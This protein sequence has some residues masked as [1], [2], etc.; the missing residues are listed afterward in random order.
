MKKDVLKFA[1]GLGIG[2]L[3][4]LL[5]IKKSSD[6]EKEEL[7]HKESWNRERIGIFQL[8][9]KGKRYT[10]IEKIIGYL[11][12]K[13][14]EKYITK[15]INDRNEI[16]PDCEKQFSEV[17]L[18]K[19]ADKGDYVMFR[20]FYLLNHDS[21]QHITGGNTYPKLLVDE[22]IISGIFELN[23]SEEYN[24]VQSYYKIYSILNNKFELSVE[25][26]INSYKKINL[27]IR[28]SIEYDNYS[29]KL[30]LENLEI[31]TKEEFRNTDKNAE[32]ISESKKN[33]YFRS[34]YWNYKGESILE[35]EGFDLPLEVVT[36]YYEIDDIYL[37]TYEDNELEINIAKS[38]DEKFRYIIES[39]LKYLMNNTDIEINIT[40]VRGF[41]E[42]EKTSESMNKLDALI[43]ETLIRNNHQ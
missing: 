30:Y 40:S 28:Y 29:K 35:K 19:I 2:A 32:I 33:L 11:I 37:G 36:H 10:Y 16:F 23:K 13:K 5:L 9:Y 20:D 25:R 8:T 18:I 41:I 17:R 12:Y 26:L 38:I 24:I 15:Y 1:L 4:G 42:G 34:R 3:G 22:N 7:V 21:I 39:D 14:D 6:K 43:F 31:I 27:I